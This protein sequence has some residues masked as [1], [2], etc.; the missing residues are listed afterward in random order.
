MDSDS[1]LSENSGQVTFKATKFK[2]AWSLFS[3][4]ELYI[5]RVL[6]N[7]SGPWL[8]HLENEVSEMGEG[9]QKLQ[10]PVIK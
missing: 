6:I 1:E 2:T 7:Q 3:A 5:L 9:D 10:F 4:T 8:S